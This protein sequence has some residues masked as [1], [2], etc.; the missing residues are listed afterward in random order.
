MGKLA[1]RALGLYG[2]FLYTGDG[3]VL[4]FEDAQ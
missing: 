1:W 2:V 4:E 3:S